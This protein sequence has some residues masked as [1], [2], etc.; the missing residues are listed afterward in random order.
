[1]RNWNPE[2]SLVVGQNKI[3]FDL[4]YEELKRAVRR[5]I[6]IYKYLFWSYLWGIETAIGYGDYDESKEF[7]SYLWGIETMN[8]K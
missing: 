3:G 1:M 2:Q 4:T 5:A 7:W 8:S 6:W